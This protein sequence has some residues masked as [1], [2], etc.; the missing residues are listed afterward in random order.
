MKSLNDEIRAYV[1]LEQFWE[2]G[3][4]FRG[5]TKYKD[6][7]MLENETFDYHGSKGG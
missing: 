7:E 2:S 4:G 3:M 1:I 6:K 5:T